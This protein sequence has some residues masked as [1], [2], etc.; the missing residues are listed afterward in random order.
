VAA[1]QLAYGQEI[2][3][4][5]EKSQPGGAEK[6]VQLHR[7][8]RI[9]MEEQGIDERQKKTGGQSHLSGGGRGAGDGRVAEAVEED[10][11]ES[12]EAC[13]R[14]RDADIEERAAVGERCADADHGAEGPEQ[15]RTG[16]EEGEGGVD[17]VVAAGDVVP[18]LVRPE[19]S[20]RRQRVGETGE[21]GGGIGEHAGEGRQAQGSRSRQNRPRE[22]GAEEGRREEDPVDP[23]REGTPRPPQ[24]RRGNIRR[25]RPDGT[26]AERFQTT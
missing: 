19:N 1:V 17:P 24:S 9:K 25:R 11:Q 16:K 18:H 20:D 5:G 8:P 14:S 2:E 7:L 3:G 22:R 4:R 15:V 12:D 26:L 13:Q 23:W 10:R 21:P 6:R